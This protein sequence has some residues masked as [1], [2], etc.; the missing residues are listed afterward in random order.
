MYLQIQFAKIILQVL[1]RISPYSM[2]F[3]ERLAKIGQIILEF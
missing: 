1:Q 2:Y 3:I